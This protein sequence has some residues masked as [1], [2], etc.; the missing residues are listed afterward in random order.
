MNP[1]G[2]IAFGVLCFSQ[3]TLASTGSSGTSWSR[4]SSWSSEDSSASSHRTIKTKDIAARDVSPFAPGSN[5]L[6]LDVGQVFLMGN[7]TNYNDSLGTQLHYTYGVSDLFG[8]DSSL[9]YSEHS[10]GKYSMM[11]LLTGVRMN[12]SWYD[13]IIPYLVFGLGFYRPNYKDP[14]PALDGPGVPGMSS[15]SSVVF[16]VHVGPGIDLELNKNLFFGAALTYHN[17]F[18]STTTL[19]NG[20]QIYLG[21]AYTSFFLHLGTTF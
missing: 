9:G 5:N 17:M 20:S 12:L 7:L 11:T 16:G 8:F 6:A 18:G 19:A 21:G 1:V 4:P 3:T 13:K 10:N 2:V 15:L 14:T